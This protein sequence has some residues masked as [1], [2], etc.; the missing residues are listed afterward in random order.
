M[1]TLLCILCMLSPNIW[2]DDDQLESIYRIPAEVRYM[3]IIGP[4]QKSVEGQKLQGLVRLSIAKSKQRN[5][6]YL[7]WL[8]EDKVVSTQGIDE[9]NLDQH[10][11]ITLPDRVKGAA[12]PEV[13]FT[14]EDLHSRLL[15]FGELTA[16]EPGR[17]GFQ[18]I[19]KE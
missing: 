11:R 15:Y 2:A 7:Q 17:Y 3:A 9:I 4:W 10:F 12:R 14:L 6:V 16:M 18:L 19:L 13:S 1:K 5:R 8:Q